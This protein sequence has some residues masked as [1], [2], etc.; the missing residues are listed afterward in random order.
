[1]SGEGAATVGRTCLYLPQQG[2]WQEAG[3][4]RAPSSQHQANPRQRERR[5]DWETVH[6]KFREGGGRKEEVSG[7]VAGLES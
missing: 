4:P 2:G 1:M 7:K 5:C 3:P 6:L